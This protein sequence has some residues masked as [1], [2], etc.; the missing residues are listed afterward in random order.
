M[1][2]VDIPLFPTCDGQRIT[3]EAAIATITAVADKQGLPTVSP[4]SGGPLY[5]GHS[6]R[7]GGAQ[8]LAG[9]GVDPLRIQSMGRWRS[10]LVIR[11]SGNK[12]SAGITGDTIRG[13]AGRSSSSIAPPS[14]LPAITNALPDYTRDYLASEHEFTTALAASHGMLP[15]Y[16]ENETSKVVHKKGFLGRTL[17]GMQYA[18][19]IHNERSTLPEDVSHTYL[20]ARCCRHE[21]NDRRSTIELLSSDSD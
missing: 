1:S 18:K 17:C 16:I 11:Y 5:G 20:C 19:W 4:S 10:S 3:K 7:T 12:G 6:L 8:T 13:L 15:V 21:R 2:E 9:L 14:T